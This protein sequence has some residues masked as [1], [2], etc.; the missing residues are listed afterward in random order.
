VNTP[1]TPTTTTPTVHPLTATVVQL[2][3]LIAQLRIEG[4]VD[5]AD[6]LAAYYADDLAALAAHEA[7]TAADAPAAAPGTGHWTITEALLPT[8][9]SSLNT[10]YG[11]TI[12]RP[13]DLAADVPRWLGVLDSGCT[14]TVTPIAWGGGETEAFAVTGTVDGDPYEC[15]GIWTETGR[16]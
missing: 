8:A 6:D 16:D 7:R 1:N 4:R 11:D 2:R 9:M 10:S 14:P 3:D 13:A 15:V 5:T 12:I